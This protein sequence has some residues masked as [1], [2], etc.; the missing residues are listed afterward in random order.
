VDLALEGR[1]VIVAGASRGIGRA[2]ARGFLAEGAKV[3]LTGRGEDALNETAG[4]FAKEF[5]RERVARFAGDMTDSDDIRA[6]IEFG[7][8]RF[9]PPDVLVANVGG[10]YLKP[11]WDVADDDLDDALSH[12]LTGTIRLVRET[13]KHMAGRAGAS[14]TVISSIAGVD[15]MGAPFA[16]GVAKAGLNHYVADLA[17]LVGPE[18]RVNAV[19]PGNIRFE[20]G[21]WD[22][23]VKANPERLQ[24]WIDR[25]VA[26]KRFGSVEE[27]ADVTVFLASD[28]AAFVTGTT[29]IADGGQVRATA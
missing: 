28:R 23:A 18:V 8:D 20:G 9:G 16:Y 17:R 1:H 7:V 3:L 13:L 4:A 19:A 22:E 12:N 10:G 24:R 11:G 15:A 21:T 25:E 26:L 27:I 2:I 14:V 5:D 29:W 6:A